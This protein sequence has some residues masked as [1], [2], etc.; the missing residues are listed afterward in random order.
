MK[1]PY[2]FTLTLFPTL[3]DRPSSPLAFK[4]HKDMDLG[5]LAHSYVHNTYHSAWH[6]VV[7][8]SCLKECILR[9]RE[10]RRQAY[11][12][13]NTHAIRREEQFLYFPIFEYENI[14]TDDKVKKIL[15]QTPYIHLLDSIINIYYT[16]FVTYLSI[17]PSISPYYYYF[18]GCISK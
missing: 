5:C 11:F 15:H 8:E 13:K 1:L 9:K 12:N 4:H 7:A 17:S 14:Q 10:K 3:W 6:T 18:W 2:C 16:W